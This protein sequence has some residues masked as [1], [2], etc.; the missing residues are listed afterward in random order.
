MNDEWP[1][2]AAQSYAKARSNSG[3][4]IRDQAPKPGNMAL[5]RWHKVH[6]PAPFSG[7]RRSIS[8]FMRKG[9]SLNRFRI[10]RAGW[11]LFPRMLLAT[12]S[13]LP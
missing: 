7:N 1:S 4:V 5:R 2:E 6:G 3:F 12:E 11:G 13:Q 8:P 10:P 9:L